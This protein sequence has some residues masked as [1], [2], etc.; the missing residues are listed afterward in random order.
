MGAIAG[1]SHGVAF[2]RLAVMRVRTGHLDGSDRVWLAKLAVLVLEG[3]ASVVVKLVKRSGVSLEC[4]LA[5]EGVLDKRRGG[6]PCVLA[7]DGF[8]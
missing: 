8:L 6:Q 7:L 4:S 1:N 5:G 3:G 2:G